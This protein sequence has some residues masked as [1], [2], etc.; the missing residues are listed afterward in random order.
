M[1]HHTGSFGAAGS[2]ARQFS[3][4]AGG[5]LANQG[6]SRGSSAFLT[7]HSVMSRPSAWNQNFAGQTGSPGSWKGGYAGYR[8][9]YG[10]YNK[11]GGYRYGR[12]GNVFVGIGL[13]FF[14]FSPFWYGYGYGYG[15][16]YFGYS[17]FGY[18][19]WYFGYPYFGYG[20]YYGYPSYGYS[21]YPS[22]YVYTADGYTYPSTAAQVDQAAAATDQDFAAE[23]EAA[24]RRGDYA[25]AIRAW[26]HALVDQPEN[27]TLVLM[28]AQALFATGQYNEA[29]GAV[30]AGLSQIPE[31]QWGVVV[32]NYAELYGNIGDYTTQLRQ[33]E[34]AAKRDP[35][36]PALQFL[37][38]YHYGFLGYP[39]QAEAVLK[40]ATELAP[41]D[42]LAK[43]L[44]ELM[45]AK[46][47]AAPALPTQPGAEAPAA[48]SGQAPS[49]PTPPQAPADSSG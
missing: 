22:G 9:G 2:G 26:R 37:L 34:A 18:P 42:P 25:T 39:R 48:E 45:Q 21:S 38:G 19:W 17:R 11:Y 15:Y 28:L 20:G 5:A 32:S 36:D 10:G 7:R 6:F 46:L 8:G 3:R 23:G 40:R 43:R 1:R 27:A 44:H 29:A 4:S 14:G 12:H 16:P 33:L 35:K 24:F 41:Q 49:A 31:D 13:P 47:P 30:Q